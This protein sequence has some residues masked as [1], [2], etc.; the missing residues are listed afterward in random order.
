MA[1]IGRV[2]CRQRHAHVALLSLM[3]LL[4]PQTSQRS[5][6]ILQPSYNKLSS[7]AKFPHLSTAQNI[8]AAVAPQRRRYQHRPL[9]HPDSIRLLHLQPGLFEDEIQIELREVTL[10]QQ[11]RYEA[12]SYV[13]GSPTADDPISCHGEE[14]FVTANCVAAT[15]RLRHRKKHRTLWIDAICINQNSTNER[16][17]Q[18]RLMGNVY[19][20]ATRA[21]IWLGEEIKNS[22]SVMSFL[23]SYDRVLRQKWLRQFRDFLLGFKLGKLRGRYKMTAAIVGFDS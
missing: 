10:S 23:I 9:E 5:L 20:K 11:L 12:L 4:Q 19:S 8:M 14:L 13:W 18:V 16:N 17:H 22:D 6:C 15:R 2:S 21:I 1:V 3:Q 7:T